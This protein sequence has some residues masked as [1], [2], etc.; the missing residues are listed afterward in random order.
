MLKD[1]VKIV[2]LMMITILWIVMPVLWN[3]L[4]LTLTQVWNGNAQQQ[5]KLNEL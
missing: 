3:N 1:K 4:L 5:K 2:L